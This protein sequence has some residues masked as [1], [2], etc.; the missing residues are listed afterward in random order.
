MVEI[1]TKTYQEV[2]GVDPLFGLGG[3]K[4]EKFQNFRTNLQYNILRRKI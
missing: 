1:D 4:L 3:Q 2:R